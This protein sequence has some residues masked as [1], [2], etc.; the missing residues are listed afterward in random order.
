MKINQLFEDIEETKSIAPIYHASD[1]FVEDGTVIP[2]RYRD[3]PRDTHNMIHRIANELSEEKFGLS[4][5]NLLFT[6]RIPSMTQGF[7][8]H[9]YE[10][11]P[12]GDNVKYF[13]ADDVEDF[14]DYSMDF[15]YRNDLSESFFLSHPEIDKNKKP[16]VDNAIR[17]F[18]RG[19]SN[20]VNIHNILKKF[21]LFEYA[22]EIKA[23]SEKHSYHIAQSYIDKLTY[24]TNKSKLKEVKVE[25]MVYAPDGFKVRKFRYS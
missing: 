1:N 12:I 6:Y 17:G 10:V 23:L 16:L 9:V 11:L 21:D 22:D 5:R 19:K 4:V 14:T 15:L 20:Y 13:Y 7:G 3:K 2:F 24:V 8:D 18:L 25:I